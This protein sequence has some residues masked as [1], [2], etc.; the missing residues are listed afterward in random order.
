MP[1]DFKEIFDKISPKDF[2]VLFKLSM[3]AAMADEHG[4]ELVYLDDELMTF[5]RKVSLSQTLKI[6]GDH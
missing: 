3:W 2:I 4:L 1:D 5:K 6:N